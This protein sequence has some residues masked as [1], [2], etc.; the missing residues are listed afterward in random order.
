MESQ[1]FDLKA[2]SI[3]SIGFGLSFSLAVSNLKKSVK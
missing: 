3:I 1:I 2:A